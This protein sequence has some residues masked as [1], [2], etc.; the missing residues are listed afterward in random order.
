MRARLVAVVLCI[1]GA[2]LGAVPASAAQR[3]DARMVRAVNA[4][5]IAHGVPQLRASPALGRSAGSF[6]R[7]M[8]RTGYFGHVSR[9][10]HLAPGQGHGCF[11][12]V[13]ARHADGHPRVRQTIRLWRSS[14]P[15]RDVLLGS[16]YRW[17][18]AGRA[19]GVFDGWRTT[20]WT[21]QVGCS[22]RG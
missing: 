13:I 16:S 5:R 14:K 7:W 18:G 9:R 8:A 11:G 21:V 6:S 17:I 10:A 3:P 19:L 1:A 20:L 12:E 15:H 22:S 4:L 2:L